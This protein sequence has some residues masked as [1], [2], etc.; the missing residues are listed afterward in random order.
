MDASPPNA[1]FIQTAFERGESR[2]RVPSLLHPT[3]WVSRKSWLQPTCSFVFV[4]KGGVG[5]AI[6][7]DVFWLSLSQPLAIPQSLYC[8][9]SR[10]PLPITDTAE[11][12]AMHSDSAINTLHQRSRQWPTV[13]LCSLLLSVSSARG[14]S[15][16]DFG[17]IWSSEIANVSIF[18]P[19]LLPEVFCYTAKGFFPHLMVFKKGQ[20]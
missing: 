15:V 5:G 12:P 11:A 17:S 7:T 4:G 20:V 6:P 9:V 2:L 10:L 8:H 1:A 19:A 3:W 13:C 18:S 14:M 16:G